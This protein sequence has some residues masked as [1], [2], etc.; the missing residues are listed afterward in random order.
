MMLRAVMAAVFLFVLSITAQAQVGSDARARGVFQYD[1]LDGTTQSNLTPLAAADLFIDPEN[2]LVNLQ[3]QI[4]IEF[5]PPDFYPAVETEKDSF[6]LRH[7]RYAVAFYRDCEIA[8]V[9]GLVD[10]MLGL[11]FDTRDNA[12]SVQY[13]RVAT[14]I[15][16]K[17]VRV[18]A[19]RS[20]VA[21]LKASNC[22]VM[23][24]SFDG[25]QQNLLTFEG[26]FTESPHQVNLLATDDVDGIKADESVQKFAVFVRG[27]ADRSSLFILNTDA[28][29][30]ELQTF[31]VFKDLPSANNTS[32]FGI[33]PA[34]NSGR[35]SGLSNLKTRG[36]LQSEPENGIQ[37]RSLNAS[38]ASGLFIDPK[39]SLVKLQ[40]QIDIQFLPPDFFPEVETE[41]DS[42]KRKGLRY[43]LGL[44]RDSEATGI[45]GLVDILVGL[46]FDTSNGKLNVKYFNN[47]LIINPNVV[48]VYEDRPA[49]AVLKAAECSVILFLLDNR[50]Q[51]SLITLDKVFTDNITQVNFLAADDIDGVKTDDGAQKFVIF[52]RGG[53]ALSSLFVINADATLKE[54]KTFEVFKDLPSTDRAYIFGI[55]SA[56]VPYRGASLSDKSVK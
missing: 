11:R 42:F 6:R 46:R 21:V 37:R 27:G 44:Y 49:M 36:P 33:L 13:F 7:L 38:A 14:I 30:K 45:A 51:Q 56:P 31:E 43:A 28:T 1:L 22:S 50:Q 40:R 8:G 12:L 39:K 5:L 20:A 10:V 18:P 48:Q 16:Q 4:D 9:A 19:D 17:K 23:L 34:L 53:A 32:I 26:I 3:Q 55:S 41:K 29:L 47:Y 35:Q 2:S 15:N 25:A 24:F 52:V 54:L